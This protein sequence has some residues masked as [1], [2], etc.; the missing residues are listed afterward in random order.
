MIN[1]VIS[2]T[3]VSKRAIYTVAFVLSS[4]LYPVE[5]YAYIGPG[6]GFSAIGSLLALIAAVG[7]AIVGFLWFPIKRLMKNRKAAA[8]HNISDNQQIKPDGKEQS[9]AE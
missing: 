5:A 3:S 9:R 2:I 8:S 1:S 6:A 7:V 4:T